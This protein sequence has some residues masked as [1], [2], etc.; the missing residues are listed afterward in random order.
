MEKTKE[1][2]KLK[3]W[4]KLLIIF[5]SIILFLGLVLSGFVAY[6]RLSVND[7]YKASEKAFVIPEI[8]SGYVP[9]GLCYD[10]TKEQ[11][12]LSGYMKNG[13]ASPVY[14]LDKSGELIKTVYLKNKD[15]SNY[16]GHG[17]GIAIGGDYIYLAGGEKHCILAYDY[18]DL[19]NAQS[20]DFLTLKG[21]FETKTQT[22]QLGSAFV[23]VSGDRL[24]IGEFYRDK[25]YPTLD[26]HKLTTKAGDYNQALAVEYKLD[27]NKPLGINP[28][29]IKAYSM[30]DHVQGLEIN[31]GKIYLSTSW[32]L[33]FS[34]ILEYDESKLVLQGEKEVLGYTLPLYA[35]D[36]E[37]L[38]N[39]YKIA[40]M[41]EEMAFVDGM[42]Y[43]NCE[44]ASNKYIFGKF[45]GGKW[46]Y[47]TNLEEMK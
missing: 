5:S 17:G 46:M 24:I 37:S 44:S 25:S 21:E 7:Y 41:S 35:M 36:S 13:S 18:N 4:E 30:P 15:G 38:V 31:D 42:L 22:D 9:Q 29:P 16:V 28:T 1:K 27:S 14:V 45:T 11:F 6:F 8:S 33:S 10:S 34:H 32:G 12:I 20:D 19:V 39:D 43:V 26:S 2:R 23:T 3:L 40:P 47:K